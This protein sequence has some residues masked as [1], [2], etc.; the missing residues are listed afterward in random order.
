MRPEDFPVYV[1][2][3]VKDQKPSGKVIWFGDFTVHYQ[4]HKP[5]RED[6]S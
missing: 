4:A 2:P 5:Q 3:A 6:E 1:D